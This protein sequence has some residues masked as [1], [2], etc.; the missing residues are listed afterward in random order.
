MAACCLG[1]TVLIAVEAASDL[2]TDFPRAQFIPSFACCS[3]LLLT[4]SSS[5]SGVQQLYA[6]LVF[7][8]SFYFLWEG[9]VSKPGHSCVL[10]KR[11]CPFA[12]S[13][14]PFFVP[15]WALYNSIYLVETSHIFPFFLEVHYSSKGWW[16]QL[17]TICFCIP[18]CLSVDLHLFFHSLLQRIA[19]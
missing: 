9:R 12:W 1:S 8:F 18:V 4:V 19:C 11:K 16:A 2:Q 6:V 14:S 5:F 17:D 7:F 13:S 10:C 15:A 3:C